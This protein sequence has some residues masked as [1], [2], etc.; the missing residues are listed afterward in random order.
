MRLM[1]LCGSLGIG[2]VAGLLAAPDLPRLT[3]PAGAQTAASPAAPPPL[4][5]GLLNLTGLSEEEIGPLVS[6]TDLRSRT[7]VTTE[8]GTVAVQSG[9]VFKHYH[10]DANEV[11]LVL[12]GSGTFWLGDR[13]VQVK[14]GDLITIPKGTVHAGSHATEG[15]FRV[16]A[17]KLPPQ[18]PDDTHRV[19]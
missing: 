15:R 11:Q 8:Y 1:L 12:A 4:T 9:N 5:P 18:R 16:L 7:L 13:E 14:P 2:F 17:I 3:T 10:A 6:G 19:P